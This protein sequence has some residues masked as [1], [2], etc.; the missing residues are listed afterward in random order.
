MNEQ[1][2][3]TAEDQIDQITYILS[4]TINQAVCSAA[5]ELS[6]VLQ[7]LKLPV[8]DKLALVK[9][10][11]HRELLLYPEQDDNLIETLKGYIEDE[12]NA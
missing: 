11:I 7:G 2:Q 6:Q 12:D 4:E 1:E 3:E 5:E 8:K 9:N 10:N